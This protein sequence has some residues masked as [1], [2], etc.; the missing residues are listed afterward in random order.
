MGSC[1]PGGKAAEAILTTH[2]HK[3]C[4]LKM[5]AA[6]M[7]WCLVKNECNFTLKAPN[8][9]YLEVAIF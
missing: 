8:V 5:R 2:P 6:G 9:Q 3:E 7:A 1:F 4:R